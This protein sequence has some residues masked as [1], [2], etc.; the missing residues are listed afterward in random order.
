MH[1]PTNNCHTA[2]NQVF[3]QTRT[4]SI[5]PTYGTAESIEGKINLMRAEF[6][7]LDA[8]QESLKATAIKSHEKSEKFQALLDTINAKLQMEIEKKKKVLE[9]KENKAK[10]N[11]RIP[12]HHER[13]SCNYHSFFYFFARSVRLPMLL[14]NLNLYFQSKR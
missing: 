9:E 2:K 11:Y 3:I 6:A 8:Q 5:A 10:M 13:T 4:N 14:L 1:N 7:Q 12:I